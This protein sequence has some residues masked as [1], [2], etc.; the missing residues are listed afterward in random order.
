MEKELAGQVKLFSQSFAALAHSIKKLHQEQEELNFRFGE[1]AAVLERNHLALR[2][3]LAE[4]EA[5]F[6][7]LDNILETVRTGIVAVDKVGVIT[8]FNREAERIS[9]LTAAEVVGQKY[10]KFFPVPISVLETLATAKP[11]SGREKH[12]FNTEGKKIPLGVSTALLYDREGNL[13]GALEVMTDLSAYKT[14]EV[15]LEQSR[16]MAALGEMAALVAHEVRNPLAGISGFA[17]LL[18]RELKDSNL[19]MMVEKILD[20]AA[21][22]EHLVTALLNYTNRLELNQEPLPLKELV[23]LTLR[24]WEGVEREFEQKELLIRGDGQYLKMAL[25]NLVENAFQAAGQGGKVKIILGAGPQ[26][27]TARL[28]VTD[29]GPGIPPETQKKI[30]TPFYTTREDGTGLGLAIVKKIVEAHRGRVWVESLPQKGAA[31]Y[32][33]LPLWR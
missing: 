19:V 9:G 20:G 23:E 17:G 32:I 10:E 3:S 27:K 21:D 24:D 11:I 2:K 28:A 14:L 12:L 8:L 25:R 6:L 16:T 26:G 5:L 15:E 33:E 7:F 18:K 13:S 4:E 30:F 1:L 29:D 31:F 22:L